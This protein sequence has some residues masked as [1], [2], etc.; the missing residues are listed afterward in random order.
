MTVKLDEEPLMS[1]DLLLPL[2]AVDRLQ[3]SEGLARKVDAVPIQV[4]VER[5]PADWGLTRRHLSAHTIYDPLQHAKVFAI[6]GPQELPVRILAEPVDVEDFG[7]GA[8]VAAHP[9]PV[10]EI[11]AHVVATKGQH[12]HG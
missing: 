2:L 1:Y 7:C 5:S 3:C 8:E 4:I 11:V 6:P 9:D 10:P 12:G